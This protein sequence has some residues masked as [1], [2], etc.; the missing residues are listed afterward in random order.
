MDVSQDS[1]QLITCSSDKTVRLWELQFGNVV[2]RFTA[3]QAAVTSVCMLPTPA[4][5]YSRFAFSGDAEGVIKQWDLKKMHEV[6][7]LRGPS[8][9]VDCLAAICK[10]TPEMMARQ[11]ERQEANS[12]QMGRK[13]TK[14]ASH[15]SDSDSAPE[16]DD[17]NEE[18]LQDIDFLTGGIVVAVSKDWSIRVWSESSEDLIV[19]QDEQETQREKDQEDNEILRTEMVLPGT[20][21]TETEALGRPT[22]KTIEGVDLLMQAIDLYEEY[23]VQLKKRNE[24]GKEY[25][26]HPLMESMQCGRDPEKFLLLTLRNLRQNNRGIMTSNSFEHLLACL[27]SNYT[28]KLLPHLVKW[29]SSKIEV[30]VC[31]R[32][33]RLLVDM[34]HCLVTQDETCRQIFMSEKFNR[35]L[36]TVTNVK[37]ELATNLVGLNF[38]RYS[39]EKQKSLV[40]F[41]EAL[42]EK[43]KRRKKAAIMV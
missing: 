19:R 35:C 41:E 14:K 7:T 13:N 40:M 22:A 25:V 30:E 31:A 28:L 5:S 15:D 32:A 1:R 23:S 37:H 2:R 10:M 38:V 36:E 17:E 3:H 21:T 43:N 6:T 39:C 12:K 8:S 4:N 42:A 34:N 16:M 9:G 29:L 26:P 11:Q 33:F 27:H 24:D 18:D 20:V